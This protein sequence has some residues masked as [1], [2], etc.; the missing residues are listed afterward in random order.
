M[1][2]Q[3]QKPEGYALDVLFNG[4]SHIY[5][6]VK[7]EEQRKLKE[8]PSLADVLA[9]DFGSSDDGDIIL[10]H[11]IWYSTSFISFIDLFSRT[12]GPQENLRRQFGAVKNWRNKVAAHFSL[13]M[14]NGDS[15]MIQ[16]A[17]V[18]QFITWN[19][20]R[21]SVGRELFSNGDTGESTPDNLG[22]G[23]H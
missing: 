1:I 4:L 23:A 18:N 17:S 13:V 22:V 16:T 21:F 11:F 2:I 20:G 9:A 8:D 5:L 3:N 14:S 6:F 19:S 10:N 12:Y 7:A 15:P